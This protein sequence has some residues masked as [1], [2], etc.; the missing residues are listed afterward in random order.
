MTSDKKDGGYYKFF[1][2]LKPLS[3]PDRIDYIWTYYKWTL[4]IVFIALVLILPL[5]IGIRNSKVDQLYNGALVN[6]L[7]NDEGK[8][9]ITD[10]WKEE[11]GG[12]EKWSDVTLFS[13]YFQSYED[14]TDA[15]TEY[16]ALMSIV[17]R[18]LMGD[19]DYL[20][21]DNYSMTYFISEGAL[22]SLT[23]VLSEEKLAELEPYLIYAV[24]EKEERFPV[25]I[26]LAES[27]FAADCGENDFQEFY[28]GFPASGS[29]AELND[30]FMD[31]LLDWAG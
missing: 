5:I 31:Y 30:E 10:G 29:N 18:L 26:N 3:W 24:N 13:T 8:T 21:M 28:I 6:V 11:L 19:L 16:N 17:V 25:A 20:M 27:A 12:D 15:V 22:A 9:Y 7:L 1:A 4:V 23:D 2:A 14:S